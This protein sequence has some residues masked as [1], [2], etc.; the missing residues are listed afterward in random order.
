MGESKHPE[1]QSRISRRGFLAAG[2]V[3]AALV[4]FGG[5]GTALAKQSEKVYLRPPGCESEES[6]F[7]L[8]NRC[9]RCVMV[10]PYGII[11]PLSLQAN[12]FAQSTPVMNFKTGYCDY[13]NKCME[14]CPTGALKLDALTS[15]N[16]GVAKVISDVCV[17][18]DWMGCTVCKDVCPIENAITLDE[19]NRP[20][21]DENL[22][23][24]CGLCEQQCPASS[25]R[26]Y[27]ASKLPRGI[28][29]VPR[30]SKAAQISGTLTTE[31]YLDGA[32]SKGEEAHHE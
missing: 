20:V 2:V 16:L 11:Q 29:V 10:C 4:G 6:M 3:S 9:Q 21:I 32:T 15:G 22:C 19:N 13:C 31:E 24:G 5:A 8:C 28:Y 18:W 17:A 12:F 1:I 25:L 30:T 7:S 27:S 26:A 14:V 23:N